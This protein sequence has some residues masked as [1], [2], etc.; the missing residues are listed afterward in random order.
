MVTNKTHNLD[1]FTPKEHPFFGKRNAY[2]Y[3][4]TDPEKAARLSAMIDPAQTSLSPQ[5]AASA[6][7]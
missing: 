1:H 2:C 5:S 7:P 3:A 4:N 6:Q